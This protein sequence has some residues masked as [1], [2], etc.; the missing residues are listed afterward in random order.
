[1]S[2]YQLSNWLMDY[3]TITIKADLGRKLRLLKIERN[4][5]SMDELL[6][7]LLKEVDAA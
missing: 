2:D 3:T 6:R 7:Q 1:M 4:A 5:R